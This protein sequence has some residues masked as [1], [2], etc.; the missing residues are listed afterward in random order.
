MN[1]GFAKA[2][3]DNECEQAACVFYV[4]D[5]FSK[6]TR[7]APNRVAFASRTDL[8]IHDSLA[9]EKRRRAEAK[10][11]WCKVGPRHGLA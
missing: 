5:H 2:A 11:V 4:F 9:S 8:R 7:V 6:R 1:A 10:F 3:G